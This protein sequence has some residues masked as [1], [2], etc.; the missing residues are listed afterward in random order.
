MEAGLRSVEEG[1]LPPILIKGETTPSMMLTDRMEHYNVPGV[2]IA[3]IN[4]NELDRAKGY[5][6]LLAEG[7]NP[8]TPD[9]LFQAASISKPIAAMA[10]LRLVQEGKLDLDRDVNE[11]LQSWKVPESVLTIE[12]KVTLRRLLSHTAGLTVQGFFGYPVGDE[13][14]TLLEILDGRPPANSQRI[15]VEMVP[16]SRFQYSGGGYVVLQ[17]LLMDVASIP[18]PELMKD[19]V[20]KPL[21]LRNSYFQQPLPSDHTSRS[22]SGH[23]LEGEPISGGWHL[24]PELAAAGLWTNPTDLALFLI[25]VIRSATGQ[26]NKVLSS[27]MTQE[28]L[29]PQVGDETWGFGMGLLHAGIGRSAHI[30]MGGSNQGYRCKLTAFLKTGQ[31]AVVMTNGEHGEE[32]S[33]EVLRGIARVYGWPAL[34]PIEKTLADIDRRIFD[35]FVGDYILADYPDF[36]INIRNVENKI[37]LNT[38]VDGER[39]EL[40]PESDTQFFSTIST[41]EYTFIRDDQGKVIALEASGGGGQTLIARKLK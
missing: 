6:V 10:A 5:G 31:G 13:I 37:V 24:Y 40:H 20:L 27:E 2:S 16:G 32:L 4:R 36:P 28:M 41:R 18:F 1:L 25:E 38:P 3:L 23:S 11:V 33:D 9:T 22:A 29:R 30:T 12:E 19:L 35:D 26:S 17:Q 15:R 21:G 14:P 39:R 7:G 34:Q 8:V